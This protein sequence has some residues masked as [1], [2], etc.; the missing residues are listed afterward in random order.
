M[1]EGRAPP[2]FITIMYASGLDVVVIN[3]IA[4]GAING[5][6]QIRRRQ[7]QFQGECGREYNTTVC[8]LYLIDSVHIKEPS[9]CQSVYPE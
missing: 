3:S 2:S 1:G 5:K 9:F 7:Q 8:M 4:A 6:Q